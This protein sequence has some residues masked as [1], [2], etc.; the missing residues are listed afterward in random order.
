MIGRKCKMKIIKTTVYFICGLIVFVI[1]LVALAVNYFGWENVEVVLWALSLG[2]AYALGRY[3]TG[4]D[5]ISGAKVV[6]ASQE[7]DDRRERAAMGTLGQFI[8]TIKGQ[9]AM[10]QPALPV[11]S[12]QDYAT[13]VP[14]EELLFD[15]ADFTFVDK[16][17]GGD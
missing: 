13:S 6:L 1:A 12:Q 14:D 7:S 15:D 5:M 11:P 9:G 4:R 8:S 2:G 16:T 17:E 10:T 3:H